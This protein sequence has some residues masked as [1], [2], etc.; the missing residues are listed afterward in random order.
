MGAGQSS[1]TQAQKSHA[2]H[3]LRVT[4]SSPASQTSIEPFFDFIVGFEGNDAI[5]A[6]S[7]IDAT[8]LEKIV[9][10]H[11][12]K[13]LNLLVWNS[14]T[15]TTRV[16]PI[17]P[18]R[19]WAL[20]QQA[21]IPQDDTENSLQPSL[22]GLSMRMCEFDNAT[23][24]VWHVL[25]VLEGSP[26]ESAGLVP[27]GDWII[28]WTGGILTAENDFYDIVEA[29]VDKPLRVYVYSY[30]FDNLREVVLVPNRH[31]G[32]E[33]LL[34]CIFG[35]GLLHRIPSQTADRSSDLQDS[36]NDFEDQQ[37]FV[38]ADVSQGSRSFGVEDRI[39]PSLPLYQRPS[40]IAHPRPTHYN[41]ATQGRRPPSNVLRRDSASTTSRPGTPRRSIN[42]PGPSSQTP[43]VSR[44][45]GSALNGTGATALFSGSSPR[46]LQ[47]SNS[48][49]TVTGKSQNDDEDEE[50]SDLDGTVS[51]SGTET[52]DYGSL[53]SVE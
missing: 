7:D 26:A 47:F 12:E 45:F 35:F 50:G 24:N 39:R 10:E 49:S 22:L 48:M 40:D 36:R 43:P 8:E 13:T 19:A 30:D 20:A 52:T 15:R 5:Y 34:G 44:S 17:V 14:K 38:P 31:W 46:H 25:D 29:H 16:V 9:E 3:V 18:S 28:G 23:N 33:G 1:E 42:T 53:T 2:L 6:D 27:Y 21:S 11:E 37:L 51:V 41:E 32:G 4:S